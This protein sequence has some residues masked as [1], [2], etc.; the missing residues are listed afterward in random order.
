MEVRTR[1]LVVVLVGLGLAIFSVDGGELPQA[2]LGSAQVAG[3]PPTTH[4]VAP[5][6]FNSTGLNTNS[7]VA[8]DYFWLGAILALI[9]ALIAVYVRWA[10]L[11]RAQ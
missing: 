11:E 9:L 2:S 1:W 6:V 5:T 8:N 7:V 10:V 4:N 3:L